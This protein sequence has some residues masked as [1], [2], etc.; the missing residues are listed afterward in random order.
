[1]KS[2]SLLRSR[3]RAPLALVFVACLIVA[4]GVSA[5]SITTPP[6]FVSNNGGSAG[7]AVYF[8]VTVISPGGLFIE[9]FDCNGGSLAGTAV[10]LDV[11]ICAGTS[12]GNETNAG[13]WGQVAC[14]SGTALGLNMPT[15]FDT[16][17]FQLLPGTY[18]MALV[19]SGGHRY[20]NGDGTNQAV[21]NAEMSLALGT[22]SNVAF[23]GG[24]F[25]PRIWNGTIHYAPT[26]AAGICVV[27]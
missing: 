5:Q 19:H 9:S 6:N 8:D 16:S 23:T 20:T 27:D 1:M 4:G 18:G 12:V 26:G 22:A 13:A 11:Y 21:A 3:L 17:D 10:D 15:S 7:G 2:L 14:G 24:I 25:S